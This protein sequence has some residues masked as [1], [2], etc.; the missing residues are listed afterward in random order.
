[1]SPMGISRAADAPTM[2]RFMV[3]SRHHLAKGS[4]I[5]GQVGDSASN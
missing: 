1:M 5:V 3:V 2:Q 4:P